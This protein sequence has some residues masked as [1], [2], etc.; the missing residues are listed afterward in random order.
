LIFHDTTYPAFFA[1]AAG[2]GHIWHWDCYVDDKNL[3]GGFRALAEAIQGVA[4]D[5]E[6]FVAKDLSTPEY[7]CLILQG[8]SCTLGWLRNRASRW[9]YVLRDD[10][11]PGLIAGA[12]VDFGALG[13]TP[14]AVEVF[15]P[16]PAEGPSGR[17]ETAGTVRFPPFRHGLVFR[18]RHG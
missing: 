7:W 17:V 2:S 8:R 14:Q 4:V 1:G 3:W 10:R 9:D 11:E 18:V 15:H 13:I 6:G 5:R 12:A 16:W